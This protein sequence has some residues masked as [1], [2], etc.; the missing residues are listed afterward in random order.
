[1]ELPKTETEL[2][3][4]IDSAVKKATEELT[5]KHNGEMASL[6]TKH[7]AELDKVKKEAGL[8]AEE[9]ARQRAEEM[10]QAQAQELADL[11]TFKKTT[12]LK[13]KL[14]KAGLPQYFVNDNRLINA[15]DGE[16]DKV[17]KTVKSEYEASQPSGTTHSTVVPMGGG[18]KP[19][20]TP[21][22]SAYDKMGQAINELLK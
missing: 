5:S 15:E 21:Q 14:A 9:L 22:S 20:Q 12:V 16:I 11:R 3:E 7:N 2:Q 13:D 19:T 6:R 1:M 8:S 4:I 18:A 17:I 10:A